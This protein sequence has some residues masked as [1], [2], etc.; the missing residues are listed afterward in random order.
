LVAGRDVVLEEDRDPRERSPPARRDVIERGGDGERIWVDLA[1]RIEARPGPVIGLD[2]LQIGADQRAR[3]RA[4]LGERL[5]QF[6]DRRVSTRIAS[7]SISVIASEAKQSRAS[8]SP[9]RRD[10]FN[11]NLSRAHHRGCCPKYQSRI[12]SPVQNSTPS[13]PRIWASA[14]RT[15][16]MRCGAPMM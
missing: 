7:P 1:H 10:C 5:L 3:R 6:G 13:C 11:D 2:P 15:Y 8:R 12:C 4:P 9:A 16:L 14:L